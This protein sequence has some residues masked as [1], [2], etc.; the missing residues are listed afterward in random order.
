VSVEQSTRGLE[1][2]VV[3]GTEG[4]G[5]AR[6]GAA[7]S[8]AAIATSSALWLWPR[9]NSG[10]RW[11]GFGR[12]SSPLVLADAQD[13]AV[14]SET[15]LSCLFRLGVQQGIYAEVDVVRRRN[16]LDADTV[17]IS[18]LVSVAHEFG[19]S[20]QLAHFDW[21]GLRAP[22]RHGHSFLRRLKGDIGRQ[23]R[24]TAGISPSSGER[25]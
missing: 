17:S 12:Q 19:L 4:D 22:S 24:G 16:L 11:K 1:A 6:L 7:A 14:S 20:A 10:W 3:P 21:E 23:R 5:A 25:F 8:A 2:V 18:Q 13:F 9:R 15:A